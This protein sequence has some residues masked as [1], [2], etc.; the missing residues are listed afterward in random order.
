MEGIVKVSISGAH[1]S[2]NRDGSADIIRIQ[3]KENLFNLVNQA[4]LRESGDRP[5]LVVQTRAFGFREGAAPPEAD[6][7][8]AF[9]NAES[10]VKF[11]DT[12]G[13]GLVQTL[14][15]DGM[16]VNFVAGGPE[17]SGYE[18]GGIP[19]SLYMDQS[20]NKEFVILWISPEA[21]WNYRQ[22]TENRLQEYQFRALGIP[23]EEGYLAGSILHDFQK[24]GSQ[25]APRELL[26]AVREYLASSD[27]VSLESLMEKWHN[28]RFRRFMDL[29]TR[30]AFLV[31]R[32]P[33]AGWVLVA[34]LAPRDIEKVFR[35]TK[36]GDR[37]RIINEF[38]QS[39]AAFLEFGPTPPK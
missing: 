19:Q 13:K 37:D 22:Q 12:L 25:A 33:D 5:M 8:I 23:S 26:K 29:N 39:R 31:V 17:T 11:L 2:A 27:I 1:K 16:A 38:I 3:N 14:K 15:K 7:L 6:I 24:A 20:V 9:R 32:S 30:Q 35:I 4:L 10:D 34:N 28:F 36:D 21:R 18:V